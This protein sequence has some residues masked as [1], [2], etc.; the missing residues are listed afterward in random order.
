M[1]ELLNAA[2]AELPTLYPHIQ[3]GL[4]ATSL[5]SGPALSVFVVKCAEKWAGD[6][7]LKD[8]SPD[9]DAEGDHES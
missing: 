3:R 7:N 6:L 8:L 5:Q 2:I 4:A 1:V 9:L